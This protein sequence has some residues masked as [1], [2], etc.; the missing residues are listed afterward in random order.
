MADK[1]GK[2]TQRYD[3]YTEEDHLVWQTLYDRQMK[4]LR[5]ITSR[6]YFEAQEAVHFRRDEIP[7]VEKLNELLGSTTGWGLTVVPN[8]Q[9]NEI[10]F[11]SLSD[12]KFTATT[13]LRSMSQ[14][15]YISE[16]DMFHDVF[17]H[18]PLL[19]HPVFADFFRRFGELGERHLE[20]P[21]AVE[22]LGRIY[23]FTVEFGLIREDNQTRI[24]GAGLISSHGESLHCMS[25]SVVHKPFDIEE[26]MHT[27]FDNSVMQDLYF[28]LPSFDALL[29]SLEEVENKLNQLLDR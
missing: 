9:P 29:N 8:I 11:P 23:W 22:M 3:E 25:N 2:L 12:K 15:D 13:W 21:E 5:P 18:V 16:P 19:S 1:T 4:R 20:S 28:V 14:L 17:G 10:F 7:R 24:F 6:E 27:S 26:I